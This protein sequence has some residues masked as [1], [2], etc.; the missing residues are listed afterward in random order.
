MTYLELAPE[1]SPGPLGHV[2]LI[3]EN[4]VLGSALMAALTVLGWQVTREDS[5]LGV[6]GARSSRSVGH[7][8]LVA[9]D[10]GVLPAGSA[11][12]ST[13]A[14]RIAIGSRTELAELIRAV[15][16]GADAA[17]DADQPFAELVRQVH[18]LLLKPISPA[19]NAE[20]SRR[21]Q[22]R[23]AEAARFR[24]LTRRER[25]VLVALVQ[26]RTAAEIAG[27]EHLSLPTV[28]SH[29]KSVLAKLNSSSQ[30]AA[31]AITHRSC[32]DRELVGHLR[33]VHQF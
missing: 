6:T 10:T 31:V 17:V 11:G 32:G 18:Q 21:L 20:V 29:I 22:A 8:V 19:S 14:A 24:A 7:V 12:R 13:G 16:E 25:Q 4:R 1:P 2:V 27:H 28:R 15:A 9:D 3:T 30:L 23:W 33:E 5:Q 26:G